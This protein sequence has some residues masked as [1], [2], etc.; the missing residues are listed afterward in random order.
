MRIPAVDVL[1]FSETRANL[2]SVMDRVV[3]DHVPVIIARRNT[4]SVV[5]VSL[6]DWNEMEATMHLLST[7]ANAEQLMASIAEADAGLLEEH[8]LIEP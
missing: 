3:D 6:E 1:T 7:R 5:M 8:E 2:K 4:R